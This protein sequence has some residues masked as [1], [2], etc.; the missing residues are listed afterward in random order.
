MASLIR[1]SSTPPP[2][3]HISVRDVYRMCRRGG[4]RLVDVGKQT[5]QPWLPL[6]IGC[7]PES[8]LSYI[9]RGT[10]GSELRQ[11][12]R[13]IGRRLPAGT[14]GTFVRLMVNFLCIAINS[15]AMHYDRCYVRW[16]TFRPVLTV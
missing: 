16:A 3:N 1:C 13:I 11:L 8:W 15:I 6:L 14:K 12:V 4:H 10:S 5:Q 9:S 7:R 2:G